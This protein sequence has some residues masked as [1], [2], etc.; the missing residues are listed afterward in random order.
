MFG[1]GDALVSTIAGLARVLPA[2]PLIGAGRTHLQPVYVM[3]VA[4]A[5]ARMLANPGTSGRTYELGGPTV[6]TLR[7]LYTL[8]LNLVGSRR[9]LVPVPF[10]LAGLLARVFEWLPSPPLTTGQVDLLKSDNVATGAL[11]GLRE[12]GIEPKALAE[13]AP[14][15]LHSTHQRA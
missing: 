7:E 13:I 2:L 12:L 4:E 5:I 14:S 10:A 9:V 11:P 3:D 8:T 6:Y 1:P 15:Y